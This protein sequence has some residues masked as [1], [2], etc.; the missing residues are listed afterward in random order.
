MSKLP[1]E[2]R[3]RY[4]LVMA[5]RARVYGG[6]HPD[7][8]TGFTVLPNPNGAIP[9]RA[10]GLIAA[11]ARI[12]S[13]DTPGSFPVFMGK[14]VLPRWCVDAVECEGPRFWPPRRF[15]GPATPVP[16]PWLL[17]GQR[18][19]RGLSEWDFRRAAEEWA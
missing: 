7:D 4:M 1:D 15:S 8:P 19:R 6:H 9:P 5:P 12:C 2:E 10:D 14:G 11:V 13:P 18:P 16:L 17:R 3:P